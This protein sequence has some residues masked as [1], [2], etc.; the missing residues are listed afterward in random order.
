M[1]G[2][3]RK[4]TFHS[5]RALSRCIFAA[6]AD[7]PRN[8]SCAYSLLSSTSPMIYHFARTATIPLGNTSIIPHVPRSQ[9]AC[10]SGAL[11]ERSEFPFVIIF[12]N[13]CSLNNFCPPLPASPASRS[14]ASRSFLLGSSYRLNYHHNLLFFT[15]ILFFFLPSRSY[16]C[17]CFSILVLRCRTSRLLPF[18]SFCVRYLSPAL[19]TNYFCDSECCLCVLRALFISS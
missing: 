11:R 15:K 14:V 17:S 8:R 18:P 1:T 10:R 12:E 4:L 2:V 19:R 16:S 13:A 9:R 3:N 7:L 6:R 5:F